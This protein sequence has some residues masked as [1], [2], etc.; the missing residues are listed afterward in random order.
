MKFLV[1]NIIIFNKISY[2]ALSLQ[3]VKIQVHFLYNISF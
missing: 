1:S 3:Q 2:K